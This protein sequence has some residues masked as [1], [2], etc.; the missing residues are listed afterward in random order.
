MND[1][2][3]CIDETHAGTE[4]IERVGERRSLRGLQI[5]RSSDQN[6]PADMGNDQPHPAPCF[7]IDDAVPLTAKDAEHGY[8][9]CRFVENG[10]DAIDE[11]LRPRPFPIKTR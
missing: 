4:T 7:V 6:R 10:I 1:T 9:G 5:E 3:A 8:A 2:A 11:A